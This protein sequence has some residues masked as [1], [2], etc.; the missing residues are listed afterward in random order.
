MARPLGTPTLLPPAATTR[1][2]SLS[3]T[4]ETLFCTRTVALLLS[5]LP[6]VTS[7]LA[8]LIN[9]RYALLEGMVRDRY[10]VKFYLQNLASL[11]SLIAT[12][13]I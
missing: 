11:I 8:G 13:S 5:G 2:L 9:M 10:Y 1:P 3:R 6:R 12:K 7:R 4:T